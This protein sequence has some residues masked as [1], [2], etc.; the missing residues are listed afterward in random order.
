ME[1]NDFFDGIAPV[2][3]EAAP[4][5]ETVAEPTIEAPVEPAPVEVAATPVPEVKPEPGHVPLNALLDEREKRKALEARLEQLERSQGPAAPDPNLDPSGFQQ[6]QL[7]SVQQAL[8]DTRLNMS[9]VSAKRHYGAELTE[10]A[11]AWALEKF[12]ASPAFYQEVIAQPDP[13]DH[14]IQAFQRDQIASQV[15]ADDFQQFQSWKAA[16]AQLAATGAPAPVATPPTAV[17]RSIASTPSAGGGSAPLPDAEDGYM[18]AI[19]G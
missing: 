5:V 10:Q 3:P 8:L 19:P 17:P 1:N 12:K 14:A 2:E 16:Q 15:T 11:K 18:S 4:V 6:Y 7:Q 13:Y 9:E